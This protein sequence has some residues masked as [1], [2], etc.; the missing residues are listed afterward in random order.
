[1]LDNA[2]AQDL[3]LDGVDDP[4]GIQV[5]TIHKSKSKQG[6]PY[7]KETIR[8]YLH[9]PGGPVDH[10]YS[11]ELRCREHVSMVS[12]GLQQTPWCLLR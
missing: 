7:T 5:M 12:G 3:I 2:L 4:D 1:V 9:F 10:G 8:A 6:P 11:S